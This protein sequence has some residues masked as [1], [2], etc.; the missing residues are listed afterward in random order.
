MSLGSMR[1]SARLNVAFA[2]VICAFVISSGVVFLSIR[3]MDTASTSSEAS[4]V[5]SAQAQVLMTKVLEQTNAVRG[6]VIKGDPKFK[7][8]YLE[9]KTDFDKTLD[10]MDALSSDPEHKARIGKMRQAMA[11]WRADIGDKVVDLMAQPGGQPAAAILSGA[12][13][14]GPIR[15]IQSDIL[16]AADKAEADARSDRAR[17]ALIGN[18]SI[19]LGGLGAMGIA[20]LMGWLLS[21]TIAKPVAN[22]TSVMRRLA[23]GDNSVVV[24]AL[25]RKDEVGDM[26]SAVLSFKEAAIEKLRLEAEATATREAV[27]AE[28]ARNEATA[29]QAAQELACVVDALGSGL[30]RLSEGDLSFRVTEAFAERFKKLQD[31]F[32]SAM[33]TLQQTMT[34]IGGNASGIKQGVSEISHASDDLARRTEHQAA[35]L[36]ETAAALDHITAT[37]R[38]SSQGAETVRD[39]VS[40]AK[41]DAEQSSE[42]VRRA[43]E[44]MSGIETSSREISQ[45]VGVIDEIAFQ[46]NLLALNA[47]VE[48]ARAGEAGRGFAVV[49]QEVRGLAQRSAEAAK[50]IKTL[51]ANS[52]KHVGAGVEL[53]GATGEVLDR[54]AGQV[55]EISG[56]IGDI[57]ASAKDQASSLQE[58]N[59]AVGKMD[60]VV[61]QNAAMVEESTAATHALSSETTELHRLVGK[62]RLGTETREHPQARMQPQLARRA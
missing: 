2:V 52:T 55:T 53:V 4:L 36:E 21:N 47:G 26:A 27:R 7:D 14:L 3:Q 28:Q 8:T 24:P 10:K 18:L 57:A 33:S 22:M 5:V 62:F 1:L 46:T 32:N 11:K 6:Y 59:A 56:L 9:S 45:I 48:A 51:I 41:A 31:D 17:A 39:L 60:Q 49:A 20:G 12:K 58:V 50:Q 15:A 61:Q 23:E 40:S 43:V 44:A 37:V 38:K 54:I 35:S 29:A 16:A 13:G 19:L 42:V 25:A 34:V 30:A